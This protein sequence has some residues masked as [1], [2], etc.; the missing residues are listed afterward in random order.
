MKKIL[1]VI[2]CGLTVFAMSSCNKEL[3]ETPYSFISPENVFSNEDGLKRATLGAYAN[4]SEYPWYNTL[5]TFYYSECGY[6]YSSFGQRGTGFAAGYNNF[7]I[8]NNDFL[9]GTQWSEYFKGIARANLVIDNASRAVSDQAVANRY[10]AEA[11]LLRAFAYFTLTRW[12]GDL[13]IL[14]KSVTSLGQEDLIFGERKPVEEVY[15][16]IESDLKFAESNLPDQWD[17]PSDKGRFNAGVAK[18]LLGKVYLTM[19]GKPLSKP[20][21][22]EKAVAKLKEVVGTANEQKYG[23]QLLDDFTSVFSLANERNPEL[24]ISF[25]QIAA[26]VNNLEASIFPFFLGPDGFPGPAQTAFGFTQSFYDL[27]EEKD[28]RRDFTAVYRYKHYA[29]G[30]S[31][32]YDPTIPGYWNKTQNRIESVP[33]SGIAFGKFGREPY[34]QLPWAYGADVIHMR[35]SDALLCLAEALNETGQS[36]EALQHL[37]RVR[38]RAGA[39]ILNITDQVQL[40]A[41]IRKERLLELAGE[42]TTIPDIRRWG[43]L[44]EEIAAMS[45]NQIENK[46]LS[47][48]SPKLELYPIPQRE[49]DANPN[50]RQN[51]GY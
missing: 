34:N 18:A 44:Q 22:F 15:K 40:R 46:D 4:F 38:T 16:L 32:V 28:V 14:D 5:M 49:I 35:F 21:N 39:T 25:G 50:M 33:R 9:F 19:A 2:L 42:F 43:T 26:P 37:N 12:Y 23:F 7:N 48:Y 45:P 11:R 51:P 13:P 29:T 17:S 20:E 27:F 24:L 30:D 31:I 3:E 47:P 36:G 1:N 41:A 6:R 8:N 10:I